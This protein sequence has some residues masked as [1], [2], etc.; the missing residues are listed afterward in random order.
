MRISLY[1]MSVIIDEIEK[2]LDIMNELKKWSFNNELNVRWIHKYV[3]N[4]DNI[5]EKGD[6]LSM[7]FAFLELYI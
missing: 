2:H 4:K 6:F 1:E 7:E 5:F 3:F